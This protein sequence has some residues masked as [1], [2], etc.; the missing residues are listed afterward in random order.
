M[1]EVK[2]LDLET[3]ATFFTLFHFRPMLVF[4]GPGN[5]RKYVLFSG[6]MEREQ[7][8]L[9]HFKAF[10][11]CALNIEALSISEWLHSRSSKA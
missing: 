6:D 4:H 8:P 1:P 7:W 9:T 5:T 2:L 3:E 11:F 10:I